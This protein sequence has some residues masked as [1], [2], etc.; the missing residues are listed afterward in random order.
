MEN[1]GRLDD[2]EILVVG[3]EDL[4]SRDVIRALV[5]EDAVVTAAA[6]DEESLAQLQRDLELYRTRANT[7]VIDLYSCSEM[8]LFADNLRSR[9]KLPHLVVCCH[10]QDRRPAALALTFLQPS[11]V[12]DALPVA[13]TRLGRVL[14]TLT[15]PTLPDLLDGTRRRGLFD[16]DMGPQRVSIGAYAFIFRRWEESV[17]RPSAPPPWRDL[18]PVLAADRSRS[19]S[20]PSASPRQ[21]R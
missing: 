14:A 13:T 15:I 17:V 7:A 5:A 20:S 12:L 2:L 9:R 10:A 4:I 8:R 18:R 21:V 3:I 19:A 1:R 16:P 11:F 6:S